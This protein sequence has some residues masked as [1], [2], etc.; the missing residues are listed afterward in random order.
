MHFRALLLVS[1]IA[2]LG[3]SYLPEDDD[4]AL[5]ERNIS[6]SE[7]IGS[8]PRYVQLQHQPHYVRVRD[9]DT[10]LAGRVSKRS[11]RGG[12]GEGGGGGKPGGGSK[13]GDSKPTPS[14]DPGKGGPEEGPCSSEKDR[15][16]TGTE[17]GRRQGRVPEDDPEDLGRA[18][19]ECEGVLRLRQRP[20]AARAAHRRRGCWWTG[21]LV[22]KAFGVGGAGDN[23]KPKRAEGNSKGGCWSVHKNGRSSYY[24]NRMSPGDPCGR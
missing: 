23:K 14:K 2:A 10:P 19:P 3:S 11:P 24:S 22:E 15:L 13:P 5:Y 9:P 12:G 8:I 21:E 1:S 4:I 18:E 17:V 16:D 7:H 6:E 20:R